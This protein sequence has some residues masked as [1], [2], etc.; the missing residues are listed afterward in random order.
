[1][2]VEWLKTLDADSVKSVL[3]QIQFQ[4]ADSDPK[5]MITFLAATSGDKVAGRVKN[6]SAT[7]PP[8]LSPRRPETRVRLPRSDEC[9]GKCG[10]ES[11]TALA[12][13]WL[14]GQTRSRRRS[15]LPVVASRRL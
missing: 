5:S 8:R 6:V 13:V 12:A 15:E 11:V 7:S 3:E 2:A 9:A 14:S 1:M 4:W 10:K